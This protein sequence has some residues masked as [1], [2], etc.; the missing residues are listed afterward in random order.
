MPVEGHYVVMRDFSYLVALFGILFLAVAGVAWWRIVRKPDAKP[1][2]EK[3]T[4]RANSAAMVI[5][6]AF[7]LSAVAAVVA[8]VGWFQR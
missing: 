8:I 1:P 5:V 6:I 3:D 4:R 2:T 7:L